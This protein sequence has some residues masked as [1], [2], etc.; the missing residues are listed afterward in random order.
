[1]AGIF[2]A[3]YSIRVRQKYMDQDLPV[4]FEGDSSVHR[5]ILDA[6]T[7]LKTEPVDDGAN[8]LLRVRRLHK[9]A[10]DI[11]GTL[12]R[13]EWGYAARGI[14]TQT[15]QESYRRGVE[16]AELIPLYFR[17]H[18][19][20]EATTGILIVQRL[21]VHGAFT[22]LK[23]VITSRFRNSFENHVLMIGR[24][25]PESVLQTLMQSEVKEISVITHTLPADIADHVHLRGAEAEVGTVVIRVRARRNALLRQPQWLRR[26]WEGTVTVAETFGEEAQA[27]VKVNY[28]GRERTYDF[29]RLDSIA[30]YIDVSDEVERAVNGHPTFTSIDNYS[31]GL[32]D[33]LIQQLGRET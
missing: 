12:E 30:P 23:N 22:E 21:G 26:L 27:R 32:R 15:R 29:S 24:F 14:N 2:V 9:D 19:P 28:N 18:L 20:P 1:M 6:L 25:V 13:G 11:W 3:S 5:S 8:H 10:T 16:D 4:R 31:I 33:E 17:A 7:A